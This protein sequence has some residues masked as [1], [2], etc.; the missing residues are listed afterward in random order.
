MNGSSWIRH[1]LTLPVVAAGVWHGIEVGSRGA[2][3]AAGTAAIA[4]F[5]WPEAARLVAW[6]RRRRAET[7][8][9]RHERLVKRA[10]R[11][12]AK[13]E[14]ARTRADRRPA[15]QGVITLLSTS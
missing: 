7:A 15:S 2:F 6:R 8:K 12:L 11:A 1:A 14:R 3:V 4:W 9:R 13:A 5:V 10:E